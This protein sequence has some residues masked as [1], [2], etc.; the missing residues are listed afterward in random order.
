M[1]YPKTLLE[2][3]QYFS[4]EQVC[5]DFVAAM[6]WP[7]GKPTCPDCAFNGPVEA[8]EPYYLKTQKRWKCRDC[9]RQF[10]VKVHTIFEDSPIPLQKWLPAMWLLANCKNGISSYEIHR[11]LGVTQ[12]TA[13][14][15]LQ[16]I[17]LAF[18]N[19]NLAKMGGK[20]RVV[21]ADETFIGPDPRKMHEKRRRKLQTGQFGGYQK[22]IVMGMLDRDAREVRAKVIPNVKRE[23]LM[24]QIFKGIEGGSE[25][26]TD[27]AVGYDSLAHSHFVHETINHTKEYVR[28]QVHTQNL[29]N[30]WSL[31]KR[32]LTGTYVAVEPFH[33]DRYVTEQ[34]F[35]YNNRATPD[36][37]LTDA[38]RFALAVSQISN[39]RLTYK[40]LT[41][42]DEERSEP[43]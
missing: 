12:K 13:W 40:E 38:D 9:G 36:N 27:Q 34:A 25:V 23:T 43:F 1:E 37:P 39:K 32:G 29:D 31:L 8:K 15:M 20:G 18:Q 35:R 30:F 21:E 14:F 7:D 22:A 2:A 4:D 19:G 10:P 42:K 33:L 41:G 24:H 3:I 6:K 5:I 11:A 16:R 17:R 28:G 26:H